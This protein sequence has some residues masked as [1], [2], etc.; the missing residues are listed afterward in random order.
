MN[1]KFHEVLVGLHK[2]LASD[3]SNG[4]HILVEDSGHTIQNDQPEVVI[5][6]V[7]GVV[8]EA[9]AGSSC[10]CWCG[11]GEIRKTLELK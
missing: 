3:S 10:R 4:T 6:A 8:E 2:K 1:E 5:N 11:R 7:M 9:V